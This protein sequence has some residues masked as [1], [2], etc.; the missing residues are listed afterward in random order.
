[1]YLHEDVQKLR[2][3]GPCATG[4]SLHFSLHLTSIY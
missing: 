1:M 4:S 2:K 3:L